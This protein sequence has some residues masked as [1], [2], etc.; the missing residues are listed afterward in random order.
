MII[1]EFSKNKNGFHVLIEGH[2]GYSEAGK[3]IVCAA[4]S[5]IVYALCGYLLNFKKESFKINSIE[6]GRLDIEC[7][8]DCEDYLQLACLGICQIAL[9]YPENVSVNID[10]WNWKFISDHCRHT[11]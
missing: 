6:T 9:E 7:L 8:T 5:G 10:A 1:A 2:A 11:A 4:T 3:D